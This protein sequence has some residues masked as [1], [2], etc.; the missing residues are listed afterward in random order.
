MEKS[1]DKS[2]RSPKHNVGGYR[3]VAYSSKVE[4]FAPD[5]ESELPKQNEAAEHIADYVQQNTFPKTTHRGSLTDRAITD[6]QPNLLPTLLL[7]HK[8]GS[9]ELHPTEPQLPHH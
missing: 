2:D 1:A 8:A 7:T 4:L 5:V 3:V 6:V 9:V